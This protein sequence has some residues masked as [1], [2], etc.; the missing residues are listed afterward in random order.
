MSSN[1]NFPLIGINEDQASVGSTSLPTGITNSYT[2]LVSATTYEWA[3]FHLIYEQTSLTQHS[4]TL[5][6][7]AAASEFA[8]I[9]DLLISAANSATTA[10]AEPGLF[11]PIRIPLGTRVA[12]KSSIATGGNMMIVG[13]AAGTS[14]GVACG[15]FCE[16]AGTAGTGTDMDA[17]TSANTKGAWTQLAAST[18]NP[19]RGFMLSVADTASGT[20]A[21]TFLLDIGI[22]G[23]G[24]EQAILSNYFIHR[25]S[26]H[27]IVNPW[28]GPFLCDVPAGTRIAARIQCS[29][30][31]STIRHLGV[32]IHGI[33]A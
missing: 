11:V 22:G 27:V 19:W 9:N 18:T 26:N 25:H 3:G 1:W 5:G 21:A 28:R 8:L 10:T 12:A 2:Q 20:T 15:S 31:T 29:S 13:Q 7:G 24:S 23:S 14:G 32:N 6:L 16:L 4:V 30:A 33:V 17:G